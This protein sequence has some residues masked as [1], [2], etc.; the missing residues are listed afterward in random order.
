MGPNKLIK[1]LLK[2]YLR[3]ITYTTKKGISSRFLLTGV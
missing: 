1:L 3:F 2:L